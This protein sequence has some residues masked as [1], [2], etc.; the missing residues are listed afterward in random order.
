MTV[1]VVWSGAWIGGGAI[2]IVAAFERE[3]D[4]RACA[5]QKAGVDPPE[6]GGYKVEPLEVEPPRKPVLPCM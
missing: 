1:W 2:G 6:Y 5:L 3:E 4:A